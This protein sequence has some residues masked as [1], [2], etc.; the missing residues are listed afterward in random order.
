MGREHLAFAVA[1]RGQRPNLWRAVHEPSSL[2]SLG[3]HVTAP[4]SGD[5][6]TPPPC[7]RLPEGRIAK[8]FLLSW[9]WL[10]HHAELRGFCSE[11]A[12]LATAAG[13]SVSYRC[14]HQSTV[15]FSRI[16]GAVVTLAD[17]LMSAWSCCC[18]NPR[19]SGICWL[20]MDLEFFDTLQNPL[21]LSGF[22]ERTFR[23]CGI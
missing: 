12:V 11:V 5:A 13:V 3:M 20:Q 22:E 23:A 14:E 4:G 15:M 10:N 1:L 6:L 2:V 16:S 18:R 21:V 9:L 7:L 17:V 8:A 19:G